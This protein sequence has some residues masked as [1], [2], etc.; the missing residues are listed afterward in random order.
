MPNMPQFKCTILEY[1]MLW[2]PEEA[3]NQKIKKIKLL[4]RR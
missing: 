1:A 2:K 3:V 4:Q